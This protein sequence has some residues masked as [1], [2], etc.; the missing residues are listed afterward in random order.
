MYEGEF[1]GVGKAEELTREEI[2]M[3]MGGIR[4]RGSRGVEE[5]RSTS[6]PMLPSTPAP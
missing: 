2:G 1:I 6:A 4:A 5:Q 3:M